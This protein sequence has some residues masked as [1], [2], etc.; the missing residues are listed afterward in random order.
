MIHNRR[1]K[2]K[3]KIQHVE[4]PWKNIWSHFSNGMIHKLIVCRWQEDADK[5]KMSKTQG[6]PINEEIQ[7]KSWLSSYSSEHG[8]NTFGHL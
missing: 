1:L 2:G 4:A 8:T 5:N 6:V 7:K 3:K